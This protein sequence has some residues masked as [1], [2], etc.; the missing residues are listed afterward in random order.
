MQVTALCSA[1]CPACPPVQPRC[2]GSGQGLSH[3]QACPSRCPCS[4]QASSAD[5][6]TCV[7]TPGRAAQSG[8]EEV[9]GHL[10]WAGRVHAAPAARQHFGAGPPSSTTPGPESHRGARQERQQ[11]GC[12]GPRHSGSAAFVVFVLIRCLGVQLAGQPCGDSTAHRANTED[13]GSR[14]LPCWFRPSLAG[15]HS[16]PPRHCPGTTLSPSG[17]ISLRQLW[18]AREAAQGSPGG[19]AWR[20]ATPTHVPQAAIPAPLSPIRLIGARRCPGSSPCSASLLP[21]TGRLPLPP[22]RLSTPPCWTS[23]PAWWR[24]CCG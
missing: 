23:T 9:G 4:P 5:T 7:R 20:I 13:P 1:L 10:C 24:W 15:Q 17:A 6:N 8:G 2:L 3:T 16:R 11:Q 22:R 14:R 12:G 18:V 19:P 21:G